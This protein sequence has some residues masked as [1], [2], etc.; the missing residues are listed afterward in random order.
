[1]PPRKVQRAGFALDPGP[2]PQR[3]MQVRIAGTGMAYA[4]AGDMGWFDVLRPWRP[5]TR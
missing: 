3:T 1:M 4:A 5:A 2:D